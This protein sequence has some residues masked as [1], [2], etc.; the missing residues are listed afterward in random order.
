V[1]VCAKNRIAMFSC[2]HTAMHAFI[3]FILILQSLRLITNLAP[4]N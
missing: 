4:K 2:N 1:T 3:V